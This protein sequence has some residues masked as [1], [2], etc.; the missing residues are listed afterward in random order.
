MNLRT[1]I[2][3]I[4]FVAVAA[5]AHAQQVN[6]SGNTQEVYDA[7]VDSRTGLNHLYVLYTSQN[8]DMTY[9]AA[10]PS[11]TVT[12]YKFKEMG[13]AY[14][15][16]VTGVIHDAT[17]KT[18][19]N[20]VE[21]DCGY[22]I[23]EGTTRTYLWVA[24]YQNALVNVSGLSFGEMGD[25]GTATLIVEG[26]GKDIVYYTINGARRVLDRGMKLKYLT[27][28]WDEEEYTWSEKETEVAVENFKNTIVVPA[29]LCNTVFT[30]EG[31]DLLEFWRM[32]HFV[33][34]S[35]EYQTIAVDAKTFAVQEDRK[36]DNEQKNPDPSLLGGSAPVNIT[37][38]AY[39]TDAVVYREWQMSTDPDFENLE[40]RLNQDEVQQEFMDAGI[41][42]WRYIAANA[43]NSCDYVSDIYT[44]NIGVSDLV[45][46]NVFSPGTTEGINDVWKVS[47][48]SIVD[49]HCAIFSRYGV[50]V[51]EF[52]NPNDGWDGRYGGK[53]VKAGVYF[54][55]IEARGADGKQYKLSGDI[56]I[57]RFKKNLSTSGDPNQPDPNPTDPVDPEAE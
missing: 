46:P 2:A 19:L 31:D 4:M 28:Q 48:K 51:A 44:V 47:Y 53:L 10:D 20:N 24:D 26:S 12:W 32:K 43:D 14:A 27:R 3:F 56:N 35:G 30:L 15:T 23:E 39:P 40:L 17:G 5:C 16:E 13:G 25:C 50:K 8:V 42:Y 54:Y 7:P 33:A 9:T 52:T 11:E 57:V 55:V 6:F 45:C 21:A 1:F 36:N 29:P 34:K 41:Y 37:F 38:T 18:T 49:F 22:I